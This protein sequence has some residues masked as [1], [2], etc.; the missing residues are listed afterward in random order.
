MGFVSSCSIIDLLPFINDEVIHSDDAHDFIHTSYGSILFISTRMHLVLIY[1]RLIF[2][3]TADRPA[4]KTNII[5][6][7]NKTI[8]MEFY[9]HHFPISF[10]QPLKRVQKN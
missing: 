5:F 7:S 10:R 2:S 4:K 9:L 6:T 8:C 1:S 3:S